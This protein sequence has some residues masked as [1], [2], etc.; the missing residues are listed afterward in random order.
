MFSIRA[1]V[2][3][4]WVCMGVVTHHVLAAGQFSVPSLFVLL[5]DPPSLSLCPQR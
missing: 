4:M 3:H 2:Y 5:A 1:R